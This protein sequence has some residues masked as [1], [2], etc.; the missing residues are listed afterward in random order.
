M[1]KSVTAHT[2]LYLPRCIKALT[3]NE[4][5]SKQLHVTPICTNM[6]NCGDNGCAKCHKIRKQKP[7]TLLFT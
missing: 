5:N 2:K 4:S 3:I 6:H 7:E 1:E